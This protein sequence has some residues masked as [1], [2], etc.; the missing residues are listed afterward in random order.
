LATVDPL[1]AR[2][3]SLNERIVADFGLATRKPDEKAEMLTRISGMAL[4]GAL[5]RAV[6]LLNEEEDQHV[7]QIMEEAGKEDLEKAQRAALYIAS[8]VPEFGD[9]LDVAYEEVK[10]LAIQ[11]NEEAREKKFE[12]ADQSAEA[13]GDLLEVVEDAVEDA[14]MNVPGLSVVGMGVDLFFDPARFQRSAYERQQRF[15]KHASMLFG[16]AV[17]VAWSGLLVFTIVDALVRYK[18]IASM[19]EIVSAAI[20]NWYERQSMGGQMLLLVA[21]AV[22]GSVLVFAVIK[23]FVQAGSSQRL[24]SAFE[25]KV[26]DDELASTVLKPL[27]LPIFPTG[28]PPESLVASWKIVYGNVYLHSSKPNRDDYNIL[29][30]ILKGGNE[31]AAVAFLKS[32]VRGYRAAMRYEAEGYCKDAVQIMAQINTGL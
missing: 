19:P 22:G 20:P 12:G 13:V 10:T 8:K 5:M 30:E 31:K 17:G 14:G 6:E 7:D 23:L 21:L 26:G 32:K 25:A 29:E 16:K 1:P 28:V 2:I 15:F 24:T 4:S 18:F 11:V 9:L 27:L 3:Q